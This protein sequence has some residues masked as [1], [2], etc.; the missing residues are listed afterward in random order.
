MYELGTLSFTRPL[1]RDVRA[2]MSSLPEADF[3]PLALLIWRF[4]PSCDTG[5]KGSQPKLMRRMPPPPQ[6]RNWDY[7]NCR[8]NRAWRPEYWSSGLAGAAATKEVRCDQFERIS[9]DLCALTLI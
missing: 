9:K 5:S 4:A 8:E 6:R 7:L 2:H 3:S 1:E